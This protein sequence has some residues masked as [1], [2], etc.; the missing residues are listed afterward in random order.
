MAKLKKSYFE[1]GTSKLWWKIGDSLLAVSTFITG[2]GILEEMKWLAM[3][4]LVVGV[5]GKFLTNMF[6]DVA[7]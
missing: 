5:I 3:A 2:Y 1:T 6:K 4:A 7:D